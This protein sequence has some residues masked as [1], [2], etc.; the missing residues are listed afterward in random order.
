MTAGEQTFLALCGGV[1]GA[2][3]ALGPSKVVSSDHLQ[4]VVNTE[5]DFSHLGLYISP[6]I[7]T[8]TYT[9][10]GLANPQLGWRAHECSTN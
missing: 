1:G 7:D 2:K 4:I 5:D 3:L 6:D 10:S 9:L 8:V